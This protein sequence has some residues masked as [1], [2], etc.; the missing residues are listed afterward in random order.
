MEIDISN[1]PP[2]HYLNI[3]KTRHHTSLSPT[4]LFLY[5]LDLLRLQL[6]VSILKQ[7]SLPLFTSIHSDIP[8]ILNQ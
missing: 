5:L 6:K 4:M 3:V 8:L 1:K 2:P 7:G